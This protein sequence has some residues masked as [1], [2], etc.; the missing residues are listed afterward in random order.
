MQ[1]GVF[2]W[3]PTLSGGIRER[4]WKSWVTWFYQACTHTHTQSTRFYQFNNYCHQPNY[5]R[6]LV[7]LTWQ[8]KGRWWEGDS[9]F[10]SLSFLFS[11]F[12]LFS[13]AQHFKICIL[14]IGWEGKCW[15]FLGNKT[16]S[17]GSACHLIIWIC[18]RWH[19]D[20]LGNPRSNSSSGV[21]GLNEWMCPRATCKFRSSW[22]K[23]WMRNFLAFFFT[24][25]IANSEERDEDDGG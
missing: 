6:Q 9:M 14:K 2:Y 8:G 10:F 1:C 16:G 4:M 19:G 11:F 17:R 20:A 23:R 3:W 18:S 24:H 15:G 5:E 25:Y 22:H 13:I 7:L 21:W 12:F